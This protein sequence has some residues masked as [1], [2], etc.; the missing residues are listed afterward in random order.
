MVIFS[1]AILVGTKQKGKV[2]G[3]SADAIF[4]MLLREIPQ[5][6]RVLAAASG[7]GHYNN[8]Q[9][10]FTKICS[11]YKKSFLPFH[12]IFSPFILKSPPHYLSPNN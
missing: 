2:G 4:G 5:V 8:K 12:R 7:G 1:V 9:S 10:T 11:C 3:E 6:T